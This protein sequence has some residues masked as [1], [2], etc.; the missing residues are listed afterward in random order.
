MDKMRTINKIG[1][2]F[3]IGAILAPN[4]NTSMKVI[5]YSKN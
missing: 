3:A 1:R 2:S 4:R 5:E